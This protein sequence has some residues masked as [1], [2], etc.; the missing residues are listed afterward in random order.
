MPKRFQYDSNTSFG[1][2][3]ELFGT[4]EPFNFQL[5][6][7]VTLRRS[8][9]LEPCGFSDFLT[10]DFEGETDAV[11]SSTWELPVERRRFAYLSPYGIHDAESGSFAEPEG[12]SF[13]NCGFM[14][15]RRPKRGAW[16]QRGLVAG[17]DL[18]TSLG[19]RY[20]ELRVTMK[21]YGNLEVRPARHGSVRVAPSQ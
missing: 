18:W 16:H 9:Y 2:E 17:N 15:V 6:E 20:G 21:H 14:P 10:L 13:Y 5:P 3:A 1:D 12:Q 7:P 4:P 19:A 8:A 11:F